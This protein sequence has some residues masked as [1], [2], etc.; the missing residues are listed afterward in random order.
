M[1][2]DWEAECVGVSVSISV[3]TLRIGI[4]RIPK[5]DLEEYS[6]HGCSLNRQRRHSSRPT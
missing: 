1:Y 3:S 6:P 2:L 5:G 4:R